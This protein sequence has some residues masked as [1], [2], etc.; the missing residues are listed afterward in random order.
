ME[1]KVGE[2]LK[3]LGQ[4]KALVLAVAVMGILGFGLAGAFVLGTAVSGKV[5]SSL[6]SER[7]AHLGAEKISPQMASLLHGFVTPSAGLHA[8]VAPKTGAIATTST[9]WGG[10]ADTATQGTILEAYAD[11]FVPA[12]SCATHTPSLSD[13]WVG[14]D[15]L[16]TGTVEQG[17]TYSYCVSPTSG[18]YYWTWFEFYPYESIQSV[19]VISAGDLIQAYVLY[20]PYI[21]ENGKAGIYTIVVE[22]IGNNASSF[23]VQGNPSQCNSAGC[24]SGPDGSAECISESLV[25]EGL[26]LADY[27]TATFQSCDVEI[28]GYFSGI[29]GLPAAAHATVYKITTNGYTSGLKQQVPSALSTYDYKLDHFTL[30][31]KRYD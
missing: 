11:W 15:G 3:G 13:Q 4:S 27:H 21:S 17:G 31:W 5:G 1:E 23:M 8:L 9:N 19:G 20:Q 18:P 26:Y 7:G 6:G 14:I 22:D 24:Q 2:S 12:I 16:G 28:N 25:S 30:T 29:G 10:Y